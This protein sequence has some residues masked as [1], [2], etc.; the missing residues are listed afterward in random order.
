M[1]KQTLRSAL[2][3]SLVNRLRSIPAIQR[4][5]NGPAG[6]MSVGLGSGL[7]FDPGPS[8]HAYASGNNE[9]PIQQ[10]LAESLKAGGIFYDIGA[11]VGFFTMLGARLASPKGLVYAFEPVPENAAYVQLNTRLNGFRN[12]RIVEKAVSAQSGSGEL[13]VAEYSGGAALTT[14]ARPPDAKKKIAIDI[15]SIDDVVFNHKWPA[16]SV[17]KIDVEGAELDVLKG[18]S[19]TLREARPILIY[20][21]DDETPEGFEGK[22]RACEQFLQRT[23]YRIER[24]EESYADVDWIVGHAIA[25]PS[26]IPQLSSIPAK[27]T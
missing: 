23:G 20:E 7:A 11:N 3:E 10:A 24:L 9:L 25:V 15:V 5:H 26:E 27:K 22:Y 1:W 14:T 13:W 4:L 16:P 18:M 21:I 6:R 19:R 12:V 8:N 2:P 17:V